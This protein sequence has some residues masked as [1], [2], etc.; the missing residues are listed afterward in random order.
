MN[1]IDATPEHSFGGRATL[2]PE[3]YPFVNGMLRTNTMRI[4]KISN[5]AYGKQILN[6]ACGARAQRR[7]DKVCTT[8]SGY[9]IC[10]WLARPDNAR[11]AGAGFGKTLIDDSQQCHRR[12][13]LAQAAR[14]PEFERHAQEVR[15]R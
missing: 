12:K 8:K 2:C 4:K 5:S 13:R 14:R 10:K 11:E 3:H 7:A 1:T 9:E 6:D 15:R